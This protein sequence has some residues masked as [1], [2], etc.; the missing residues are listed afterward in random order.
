MSPKRDVVLDALLRG[1]PSPSRPGVFGFLLSCGCE[2]VAGTVS[3][4]TDR[5]TFVPGTPGASARREHEKRKANRERRTR[6]H[7]PHIGGLLVALQEEPQHERAWALG[8]AG[9]EVVAALL[10]RRCNDSV[11]LL[12]DRRIPGSRAN[13]DH[14]AIAPSGVWVIDVKRYKG[15]VQVSKSIFGQAKLKIAGRDRSKLGTGLSRQVATVEHALADTQL[16]VP[17]SG[18]LCF[19]D[20][21]LPL[22]RTL[23]FESHQLVYPKALAKRLNAPGNLTD[24]EAHHVAE[25]LA[26]QFP[27]A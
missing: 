18:A 12:H 9:E 8:A 3:P 11:I 20:A 23:T 10:M 15:K 19:V 5:P 7:H 1:N 4:E 22:T 16:P 17:V 25:V 24:P 13:I 21:D 27:V 6:N 2:A 14:L 26:T